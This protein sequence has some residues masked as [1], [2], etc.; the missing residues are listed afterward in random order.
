MSELDSR[1]INDEQ[2]WVNYLFASRYINNILK[3]LESTE[4][5]NEEIINKYLKNVSFD[6]YESEEGLPKLQIGF[7]IVKEDQLLYSIVSEIKKREDQIRL[8]YVVVNAERPMF[9]QYCLESYDEPFLPKENGREPIRYFG[10]FTQ[11]GT[12][13]TGYKRGAVER[14]E[15]GHDWSIRP[16]FILGEGE[17]I[18]GLLRMGQER[19]YDG[20]P[21]Q[22]FQLKKTHKQ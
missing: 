12:A 14:Y 19:V 21:E 20:M 9:E 15:T 10:F 11:D 17:T 8:L 7:D 18:I 13:F 22:E 4:D 3:N 16:D 2:K 1:I 6:R 5:L